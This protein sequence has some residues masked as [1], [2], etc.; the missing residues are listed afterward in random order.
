MFKTLQV[1]S[2][3]SLHLL[4]CEKIGI[5][6]NAGRIHRAVYRDQNTA[7]WDRVAPKMMQNTQNP[8]L[9]SMF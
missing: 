5:E 9:N 1:I 7:K 6:N 2:P 3:N 8:P 4:R